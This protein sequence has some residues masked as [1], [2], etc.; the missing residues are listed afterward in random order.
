MSIRVPL[1]VSDE[2]TIMVVFVPVKPWIAGITA[3]IVLTVLNSV[4]IGL[5][6]GATVFAALVFSG[7]SIDPRRMMRRRA[8]GRKQLETEMATVD[9]SEVKERAAL[10]PRMFPLSDFKLELGLELNFAE[11]R[12]FVNT[13]YWEIRR[14]L[15]EVLDIRGELSETPREYQASVADRVGVAASSLLALTK[16]FELA[17]YSQHDVSRLEAEEAAK[18]AFQLL[19]SMNE[20]VKI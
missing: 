13:V 4:V 15:T 2:N 18:H 8:V 3:S 5:A 14:M 19:Q 12:A 16:L 20:M 7:S 11:P 17:E 6:T 9:Q 1:E 10:A